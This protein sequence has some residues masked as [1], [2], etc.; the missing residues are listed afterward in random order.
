MASTLGQKYYSRIPDLYALPSLIEVQ[1][2][3][4]EWLKTEGL[5]ELFD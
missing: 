1:L 3:S 2:D 5:D 4:F